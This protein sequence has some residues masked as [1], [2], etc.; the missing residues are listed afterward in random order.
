VL[1][2]H[3]IW[4]MSWEKWRQRKFLSWSKRGRRRQPKVLSSCWSLD[5][6][7][8]MTHDGMNFS[9]N[10]ISGKW[11]N[12]NPTWIIPMC[13]TYTLDWF[14]HVLYGPYENSLYSSI[15][16]AVNLKVLQTSA[17]WVCSAVLDYYPFFWKGKRCEPVSLP[18]VLVT[19]VYVVFP[20][21][22]L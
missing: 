15:W 8:L 12:C 6:D 13:L 11:R 18:Y 22:K 3:D 16:I 4:Y 19:H 14:P 20:L 5:F 2:N 9:C 17:Y 10:M 21:F 1:Q 7:M